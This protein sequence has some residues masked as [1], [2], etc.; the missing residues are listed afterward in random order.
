[1]KT[2]NVGNILHPCHGYEINDNFMS[3]IFLEWADLNL[4]NFT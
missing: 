3:N 2:P 4:I 1:M